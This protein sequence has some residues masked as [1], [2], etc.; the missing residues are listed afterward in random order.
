M[1]PETKEFYASLRSLNTHNP[2]LDLTAALY[3]AVVR[4]Q[5]DDCS[6]TEALSRLQSRVLMACARYECAT[7]G[8]TP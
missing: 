6:V 7:S 1:D 4:S 2:G 3:H 8:L 5:D